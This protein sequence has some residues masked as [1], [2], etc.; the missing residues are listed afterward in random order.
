MHSLNISSTW[1]LAAVSTGEA[2][3]RDSYM[4]GALLV[5]VAR[6]HVR[7]GTFEFFA[8]R[9]MKNELDALTHYVIERFYPAAANAENPALALLEAVSES[10]AAMVAQWQNVGFIHGVMN[11]CLLYTSP[12]PRDR[13]KYRMPSS[14]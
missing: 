1:S 9:G 13:Q 10:T 11:T 2:V 4:P 6:S 12:S 7:V 14:A 3:L 5:R 8:A